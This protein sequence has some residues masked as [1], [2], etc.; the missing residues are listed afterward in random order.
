MNGAQLLT[1]ARRQGYGLRLHDGILQVRAPTGR[2][3]DPSFLAEV[4]AHSEEIRIFM[5]IEQYPK[6]RCDI[7]GFVMSFIRVS[8]ICGRCQVLSPPPA[9]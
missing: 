9:G 3:P 2:D 6:P 1:Q 4:W 8:T 5:G 7:C